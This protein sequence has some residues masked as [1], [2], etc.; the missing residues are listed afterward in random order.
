MV[1]PGESKDVTFTLGYRDLGL[2][3]RN[4][5]YVTEPGEFELMIGKSSE[6]IVCRETVRYKNQ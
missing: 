2:W 4:M 6:D 3:N 5:E 1:N